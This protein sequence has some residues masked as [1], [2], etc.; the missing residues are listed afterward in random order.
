MTTT[1][2]PHRPALKPGMI[3]ASEL[4]N[5]PDRLER[6]VAEYMEEAANLLLLR[7]TTKGIP[8][9]PTTM[10]QR[11]WVDDGGRHVEVWV[12]HNSLTP[13]HRGR[14]AHAYELGQLTGRGFVEVCNDLDMGRDEWTEALEALQVSPWD[15]TRR[16]QWPEQVTT[17]EAITLDLAHWRGFKNGKHAGR[18]TSGELA[19]NPYTSR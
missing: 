2:Q 19:P 5:L 8:V 9:D 18:S 16:R 4:V 1:N 11:T 17:L 10:Q 13:A 15:P 3:R 6:P 12:D 7:L 14:L